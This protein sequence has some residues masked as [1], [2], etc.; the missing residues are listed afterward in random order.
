MKTITEKR[1]LELIKNQQFLIKKSEGFNLNLK[2][3]WAIDLNPVMAM[4]FNYKDKNK[5]EYIKIYLNKR[6]KEA[7]IIY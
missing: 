1:F 3:Y 2:G 6:N 5:E 4:F 7:D